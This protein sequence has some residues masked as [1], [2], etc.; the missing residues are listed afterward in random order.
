MSIIVWIISANIQ[1]KTFIQ[2]LYIY[3]FVVCLQH[4]NT[5]QTMQ[6]T[7]QELFDLWKKGELYVQNDG[8]Y[9]VEAVQALSG[10]PMHNLYIGARCRNYTIVGTSD[11]AEAVILPASYVYAVLKHPN[12]AGLVA[13]LCDGIGLNKKYIKELL[14]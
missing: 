5:T 9:F 8:L 4:I 11:S 12:E 2:A 14:G 6:I 7:P 13:H 10:Q 1:D 3:Y